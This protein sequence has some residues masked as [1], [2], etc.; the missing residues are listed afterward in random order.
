M[1]PGLALLWNRLKQPPQTAGARTQ[2]E[3]KDVCCTACFVCKGGNLICNTEEQFNNQSIWVLDAIEETPSCSLPPTSTLRTSAAV[4][5]RAKKGTTTQLKPHYV[6]KCTKCISK[7]ASGFDWVVVPTILTLLT[8]YGNAPV[9]KNWDYQ[10][11]A[12]CQYSPSSPPPDF[13][14]K[15]WGHVVQKYHAQATLPT[16]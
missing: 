4:I 5:I 2:Q 14:N 6:V 10:E 8:I 7:K 15:I 9:I 11:V 12:S 16:K 13:S 3:G 1:G